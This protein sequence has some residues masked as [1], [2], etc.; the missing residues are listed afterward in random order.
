MTLTS[1][2]SGVGSCKDLDHYLTY[3]EVSSK[4]IKELSRCGFL[5]NFNKKHPDKDTEANI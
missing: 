2:L 3:V 4:S 5:K 1:R